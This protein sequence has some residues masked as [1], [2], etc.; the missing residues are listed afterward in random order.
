MVTLFPHCDTVTLR[1]RPKAKGQWT[2]PVPPFI[3]FKER[4]TKDKY[5][6]LSTPVLS[7]FLLLIQH[8]PFISLWRG[9][10]TSTLTQFY[11]LAFYFLIFIKSTLI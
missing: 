10:T 6:Y 7:C 8:C 4:K 5:V 1:L 2:E 3:A 11:P 9:A